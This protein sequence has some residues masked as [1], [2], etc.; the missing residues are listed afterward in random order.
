MSQTYRDDRLAPKKTGTL[1]TAALQRRPR[2]WLRRSAAAVLEFFAAAAGTRIV[3]AHLRHLAAN[4]Q[5]ELRLVIGAGGR[6]R[7]GARGDPGI[8][9]RGARGFLREQHVRQIREELLERENVRR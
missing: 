7:L 8:D 1:G 4:R 5:L 2:K 6:R 9:A 3:A